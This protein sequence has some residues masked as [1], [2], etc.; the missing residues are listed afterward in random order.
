MKKMFALWLVFAL[1]LSGCGVRQSSSGSESSTQPESSAS[2][3]ETPNGEGERHFL[4]TYSNLTSEAAR[5]ETDTALAEAGVSEERREVFWNHVKQFNNSVDSSLMVGDFQEADCL[6]PA[7]DP[8]D[9]QDEWTAKHPDFDGYNC[10]ITAYSL[11]GDFISIGDTH[12]IRDG[13]LLMD[14]E[15]LKTDASALMGGDLDTF[16]RV[17]SNLETEDTTDVTVHQQKVLEFWKERGLTFDEDSKLSLVTVWLHS[18]FS[19]TENELFI[20][21]VGVLAE[22][23]NGLYFVEK[24]AF[25]APYQV[26]KLESREELNDYLMACY[27]VEWGQ[28]AAR[29]FVLENDSPLVENN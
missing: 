6:K 24:L 29:P 11:F 15:S 27:D 26:I 12:E 20:G 21:H 13:D 9:Y 18:R 7:Y 17:F 5:Q 8:Y 2:D 16:L 23:E 3:C 10:R 25:Q 19:E 22:T 1:L 28:E 14:I 4:C